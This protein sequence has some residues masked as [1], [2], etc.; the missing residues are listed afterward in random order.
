[1][2]RVLSDPIGGGLVLNVALLAIYLT[3]V[4]VE[5]VLGAL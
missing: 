2:R 4:A 3:L 1:M 5:W